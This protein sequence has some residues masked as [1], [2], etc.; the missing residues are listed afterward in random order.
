MPDDR[1]GPARMGEGVFC[2]L[3][4]CGTSD[5]VLGEGLHVDEVVVRTVL[6]EPFADILL[7]PQDHGP[8]EAAQ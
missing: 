7:R 3:P 2:G 5:G 1:V 8:G 4:R 6:L